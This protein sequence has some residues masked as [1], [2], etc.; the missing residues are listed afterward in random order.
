MKVERGVI[1]SADGVELAVNTKEGQYYLREYPQGSLTSP[2]LG[3]NSLRYGRAGVERVYNEELS[4]QSGLLGIT[5]YWDELLGKTHRGADLKLTINVAVQR[6]AAEALGDRKGAVVALDPRTGAVLAM[7]SYPRYDPNKVDYPVDGAQHRPRHAAAQPGHAGSLSS[8]LGLQDHRGRGR[9]RDRRRHSRD[10][11]H[12]HRQRHGRRVRGEQLRRQ[13]RTAS[14]TSPRRS[15]AASTPRSPRWGW[16]LGATRWPGTRRLRFR[17]G[18]ALA[19]GRGQE[20]LPRPGRHGQG[21]PGPGCLRAGRGA[22][23]SA[24]DGARRPR[25]SPTRA[26]S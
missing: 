19:H 22:G 12:R 16:S 2:W 11:V 6:A 3:Y 25:P 5:S 26:R 15:R 1:V 23:H 13:G 24:A 7:V 8:G 17:Q 21:P 9:P 14:T 20:L 18:A 4:G 10:R